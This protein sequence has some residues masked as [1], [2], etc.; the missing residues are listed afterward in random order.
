MI[1][2]MEEILRKLVHVVFD[3]YNSNQIF[4]KAM[5]LSKK[6]GTPETIG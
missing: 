4:S 1:L 6:D 3:L 2:L 5:A